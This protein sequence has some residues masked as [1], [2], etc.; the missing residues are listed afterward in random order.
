MNW[1]QRTFGKKRKLEELPP[2]RVA[3]LSATMRMGKAQK[4]HYTIEMAI[5]FNGKPIRRFTANHQGYSR[6]Q[7][8]KEA[9]EGFGIKLNSVHQVREKRNK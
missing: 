7:V 8:A 6:D 5:T 9:R 3:P 2:L 1:F 4:K